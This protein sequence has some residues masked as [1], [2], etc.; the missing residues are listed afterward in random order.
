VGSNQAYWQLFGPQSQTVGSQASISQNIG[1]VTL[2][3]TG[4][5]TVGVIGNGNVAGTVQYQFNITD[6]SDTP[7]ASSGFGTVHSGTIS[8]NQTNSFIYTAS[9][10]LP[11]FLDSQDISGQTLV[12]DL[13]SPDGTVVFS[14]QETADAGPY[15]LPRSGSYTLTV[16]GPNGSSGNF[17][18]RLLDLSASPMLTLNSAV[19]TTLKNPYETDVYQFTSTPGQALY[20][21][22]IT[23]DASPPTVYVAL[24]DPRGQFV[25]PNGG[26]ATDRGPFAVQYG[27]TC[28]FWLRNAGSLASSCAFRLLDIASQPAIPVNVG[29]TTNL[30]VYAANVFH[31]AGS[32]GQKLYFHGQLSNPSGNWTL[33]DPNNSGVP[34]GYAL[35][36]GD[37]EVTL[38]YSGQYSLVLVSSATS[39]GPETFMVND[40]SNITNS[41]TL[42]SSTVGA[43]VK[44]G[45]QRAYAFNG[46]VGQHLI[47]DALT[48]DPPSPNVIYV[49]LFDPQG[50][51]LNVGLGRASTDRGPFTL[52]QTGTYT[53]VFD[54]SGSSTGAFAFRLVD[55]ATLPALPINVGVTNLLDAYQAGIYSYAG[56]LGQHLYFRGNA[57]NPNGVWQLF[58]PND[59][60]VPGGYSSLAGD[61]Q[62][63]LPYDGRYVLKLDTSGTAGTE[64]FQVNPFNSGVVSG[65]FMLI[66]VE[67]AGG[68]ANVSWYSTPNKHYRLQY[69][70]TLSDSAWMAVGSDVQATGSITVQADPSI[71]PNGERYYRVWLLDP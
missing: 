32:A 48:N 35:L 21:D 56:T 41:Y 37:M 25:G 29:V 55:V 3:M 24:L 49:S 50:V 40:F 10:G 61:F 5:Y 53:L 6:L 2:P 42:G 67:F 63:S 34:S 11:V 62:V 30:D 8:A 4:T 31:Y 59:N 20:Y 65:G 26:F 28:Y 69:K 43:I 7:V 22:A 64:I 13:T 12:V 66:T 45:E 39:A 52:G 9:A 23:N 1:T 33:F 19:N 54:G 58:D 15:I 60:A 57:A 16:R 38:P 46:V 17:S 51:A 68:G 71:G 18:L 27:G 36:T 14:V 70:N 47:Y 44:L